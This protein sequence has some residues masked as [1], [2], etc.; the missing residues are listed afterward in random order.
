MKKFI[1]LL[2]LAGVW[3]GL[4]VLML[5]VAIVLAAIIWIV[6]M[7]GIVTVS[8]VY[9]MSPLYKEIATITGIAA[10]AAMVVTVATTTIYSQVR[11]TRRRTL[12][13]TVPSDLQLSEHSPAISQ[14]PKKKAASHPSTSPRT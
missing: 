8:T 6:V 10:L 12:P 7:T 11:L 14:S 5:A 3:A 9:G 1:A 13:R 2:I 4:G